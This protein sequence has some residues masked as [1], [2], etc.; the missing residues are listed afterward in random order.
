[1]RTQIFESKRI[2]LCIAMLAC[3]P[4][5]AEDHPNVELFGGYQHLRVGV[6]PDIGANGWNAA[7]TGYANRWFGVTADFSGA[8]SSVATVGLRAH[9]FAFGPTFALRGE[10]VTPFAHLLLGGFHASAG[11]SG[12]NF[13]LAGMPGFNVGLSGFAML[14]GGGVDVRISKRVSAR[15]FQLDWLLWEGADV[16]EKKNGRI[17]SGIVI[18][19]N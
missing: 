17:A 18:R 5:A 7:I 15:L 9:T 1:M 10:R 13:G 11:A 16:T 3:Y 6:A 14:T 12:F 4:L 8:Y 2:I 19:L